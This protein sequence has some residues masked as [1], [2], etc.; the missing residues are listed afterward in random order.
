MSKWEYAEIW[1]QQKITVKV[2]SSKGHT[3]QE[4]EEVQWPDILSRMGEEGWE[5]VSVIGSP[6][7]MQYWYYFKRPV[8]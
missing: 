3:H 1:Y 5:M 6:N 4:Y 7:G 2:F 8:V